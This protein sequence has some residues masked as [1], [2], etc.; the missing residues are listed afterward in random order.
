MPQPEHSMYKQRLLSPIG[1]PLAIAAF[2]F[3]AAAVSSA[4]APKGDVLD[5]VPEAGVPA[6]PADGNADKA[7]KA[8]I[9]NLQ[10]LVLAA[11]SYADEHNG[12]LPVNVT[13]KDGKVL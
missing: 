12:K 13:D 1:V 2:V 3:L 4:P 10:Q 6:E 5:K 7:R 11:H 8:S 9:T